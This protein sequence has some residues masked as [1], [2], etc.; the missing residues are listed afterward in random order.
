MTKL[1][2]YARKDFATEIVHESG[3]RLSTEPPK[4]NGGKGTVFSPTDLFGASL[5]SCMLTLMAMQAKKIG[6]D[7][8]GTEVEVEKTMVN[9]PKRRIG[10]LVIR[11]RCPHKP[12][13]EAR[14]KLEEAA[15]SC[16]VHLSIHEKVSREVDFI[17]G[18]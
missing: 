6:F 4:D 14:L 13:E 18:L 8:T 9:D 3:A 5:G 1:T 2:I 12:G 17:W 7:I 16:P 10:R 11:I 15:L